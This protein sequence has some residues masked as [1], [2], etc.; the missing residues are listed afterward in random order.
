M[1]TAMSWLAARP[2]FPHQCRIVTGLSAPPAAGRPERVVDESH[3]ER[4]LANFR[5]RG[6]RLET[7]VPGRTLAD[8]FRAGMPAA[9]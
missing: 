2:H 4:L 1:G 3:D 7:S 5:S 6:M 8:R 9:D